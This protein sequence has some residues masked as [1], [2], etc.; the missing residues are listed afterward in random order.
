MYTRDEHFG[1]FDTAGAQILGEGIDVC[2]TVRET[3]FP[4]GQNG[5]LL[6]ACC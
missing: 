6:E 5:S 2:V 3:F 4:S 1:H